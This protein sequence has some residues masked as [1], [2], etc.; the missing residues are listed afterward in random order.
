MSYLAPCLADHPIHRKHAALQ[1][2]WRIETG[3]VALFILGPGPQAMHRASSS[4]YTGRIGSPEEWRI[5]RRACAILSRTAAPDAGPAEI[6]AAIEKAAHEIANGITEIH[7]EP[8]EPP[9]NIPPRA[10][11]TADDALRVLAA[12]E[13]VTGIPARDMHQ[14]TRSITLREKAPRLRAKSHACLAM[15]HLFPGSSYHRLDDLL[16]FS[17]NTVNR[18][19]ARH[20]DYMR[21]RTYAKNHASIISKLSPA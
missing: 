17:R 20:I 7:P 13:L 16:G 12:V 15:I 5:A 21:E 6:Q 2:A 8:A 11:A 19:I 10:T 18:N 3:T 14:S 1:D 9:L 4:Y